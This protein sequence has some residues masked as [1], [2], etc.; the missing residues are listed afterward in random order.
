MSQR[1]D[2]GLDPGVP[3]DV[4]EALKGVIEQAQA[5][6]LVTPIVHPR[7]RRL[8]NPQSLTQPRR[9]EPLTRSDLLLHSGQW[10][11]QILGKMSPWLQLDSP[12]ENVRKRGEAAF[13]QE[14]QFASHL[15]LHAMLLPAPAECCMNYA[16]CV[17]QSL[18]TYPALQLWIR[19]VLGP[20]AVPAA[21]DEPAG[22]TPASPT[23]SDSWACWNRLRSLCEANPALGAVLELGPDLPESD[24]EVERWCGEP[25]RAVILPTSS[26]LT[27]KKGYPTL[28]RRH[29]VVLAKL[30]TMNPK[31]IV[32]GR[33]DAHAEGLGAHVLYLRHFLSKKP[34]PTMQERFESPYYDYLQAPLQ[35]LQDNLESQTYETFEKDPVKYREYERAIMLALQD[36]HSG[37]SGGGAGG[38][39]GSSGSGDAALP[40]VMVVGAGRGPLV[41][42]ALAASQSAGVPIKVYAV[43]KNDNA[44]VT[45][46]NRCLTEPLWAEHVTVVPGDMRDA[47]REAPVLADI[48]V[49]ELLGSWGDNELS[50][51]CLDGAQRY[52]RPGGISIPCDYTSYLAPLSSA[53]L[54][55]EVKA[56]KDLSHFETFY[57]V[58]IHNGFQ[59]A[60]SQPTFYFA[61][62]SPESRPDNSRYTTLR[63]DVPVGATL[64]GFAGFFHSTL[65][66]DVCISTDPATLS[67][68]MFSWFP[69]YLPLRHPVLVPDG[70]TVEVHCWRHASSNKV[71]YEWALVQPQ[72]SPIHNVNGR[73]YH[74]GL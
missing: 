6:F 40:V 65:Y 33:S 42:A 22:S 71:W 53:K 8:N 63:F 46:Q 61:H 26:F 39:G 58:K 51:E 27:N 48:L 69:L 34:A 1:F 9:A 68:G 66:R 41:A 70:G 43:E 20:P 47:F 36:R 19:V 72:M 64:H 52:L 16:H 37:A 23:P 25:L 14:V 29:Q 12:H 28:S 59:M 21:A 60:P 31:I 15:A 49:S 17:G 32:S 35:P 57:V 11:Q 67:D 30:L 56:F 24:E 2:I 62:P 38:A 3:P 54:W 50:P 45:L 4:Q 10:G 44:V 18:A 13:K 55:N 74:I 73:S 5:Q 7:Y